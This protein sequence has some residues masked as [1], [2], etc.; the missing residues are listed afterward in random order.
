MDIFGGFLDTLDFFL[1]VYIIGH[2]WKVSMFTTKYVNKNIH[3]KSQI[4]LK[5]LFSPM[6]KKQ[7]SVEAR[8]W[9]A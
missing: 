9:P 8:R 7:P 2:F 4:C 5:N 1:L 6:G 3:K